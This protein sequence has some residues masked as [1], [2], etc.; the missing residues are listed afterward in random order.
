MRTLLLALLALAAIHAAPP[1]EAQATGPGTARAAVRADTAVFAGGC[2]WCVEE[3]F[4]AVDGVIST[5]S[6]YM[7]GHVRNPTYRQV[8]SG[9]TGHAEVVRVVYDPARV[10]YESLLGVFW[11]NIDP[12]TPD[13]QFCDVG[14]QYRAAVFFRT[15]AQ[16]TA[17]EASRTALQR[18][19]RFSDPIVTEIVAASTFYPAEDYHQD[20]YLRNPVRYRYYKY[21]C[22]RAQ[23]LEEL[24]GR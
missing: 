18:S 15:D 7:G 19:G 21:S 20:Y 14:S 13:R 4:D 22:G 3:A 9:R 16:R 12:L 23:R 10:S 8:T 24:W 5:T 11:L 1:L 2:F 6:G 17:A